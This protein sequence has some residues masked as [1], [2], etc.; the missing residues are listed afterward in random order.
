MRHLTV[1]CAAVALFTL[2]GETRAV[3][4]TIARE[5][6]AEECACDGDWRGRGA[7]AHCVRR[8]TTRLAAHTGMG[9]CR[10][11]VNRCATRSVCGKPRAVTC[12]TRVRCYIAATPADCIENRGMVSDAKSCCDLIPL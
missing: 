9:V 1:A 12:I 4:C 7:Y 8:A 2:V 3:P 11:Q 6:V 10:A 5:L